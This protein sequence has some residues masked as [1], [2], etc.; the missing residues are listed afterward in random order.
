MNFSVYWND[1]YTFIVLFYLVNSKNKKLRNVEFIFAIGFETVFFG[2]YSCNWFIQNCILM[3]N[4]FLISGQ[5]HKNKFRNNLF[6]NN[7]WL[8]KFLNK[9]FANLLKYKKNTKVSVGIKFGKALLTSCVLDSLTSMIECL[10][11]NNTE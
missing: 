7:L 5:N 6:R 10:K 11:S 3:I 1:D 2:S 8:Q 4:F 9:L